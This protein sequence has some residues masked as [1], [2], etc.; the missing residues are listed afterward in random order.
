MFDNYQDACMKTLRSDLDSHD[1]IA[2]C[3][4]GM[5]DEL[6]EIAEAMVAPPG[7]SYSVNHESVLEEIGDFLWYSSVMLSTFNEPLA[8]SD[9]S[10]FAVFPDKSAMPITDNGE[11]ILQALR[12]LTHV[13]GRAKHIRYHDHPIKSHK[14]EMVG[15]IRLVLGWMD[16]LAKELGSSLQFVADVNLK[17]LKLRYPDGFDAQRSINRT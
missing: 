17:K 3:A 6:S 7:C 5:A 11:L 16:T 4:L 10:L 8:Q 14:D 13:V 9:G 15:A 1:R 12:V 2:M